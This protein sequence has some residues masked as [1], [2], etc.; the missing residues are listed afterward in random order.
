MV[1]PPP[2]NGHS[3]VRAL[4]PA[5][6]VEESERPG[7]VGAYLDSLVTEQLRVR[8]VAEEQLRGLFMCVGCRF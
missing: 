6:A 2:L 1:H 8:E 3:G 5:Q 7:L 4:V